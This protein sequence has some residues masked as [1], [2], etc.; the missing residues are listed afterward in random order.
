M[1]R[2]KR[3]GRK[4]T[5]DRLSLSELFALLINAHG[6]FSCAHLAGRPDRARVRCPYAQSA[7]D[8]PAQNIDAKAVPPSRPR[9]ASAL[10]RD[11]ATGG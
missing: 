11:E 4:K 1:P 5:S 3:P 8:D 2:K 10:S 6:G 7:V 9:Y